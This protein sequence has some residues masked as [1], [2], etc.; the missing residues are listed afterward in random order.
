MRGSLSVPYSREI[1]VY[2]FGI[3]FWEILTGKIPFQELKENPN[4]CDKIEQ[5]IIDGYRPS[6]DVLPNDISP[7]I[8]EIIKQCWNSKPSERPSL[9]KII[10]ILTIILQLDISDENE[11]EKYLPI[12]KY[13]LP[14]N[15]LA[16]LMNSCQTQIFF[17]LILSSFFL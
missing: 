13:I 2:S 14:L 15:L 4:T 8:I 10:S 11:I 9:G 17:L 3:L 5:M 6:L 1:D 7:C 12:E 16:A